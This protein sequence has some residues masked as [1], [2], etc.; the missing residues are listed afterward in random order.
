LDHYR[1]RRSLIYRNE[2]SAS[3]YI[4]QREKS[5]L[6]HLLSPRHGERILNIVSSNNNF[7]LFL[8]AQGYQ[9]TIFDLEGKSSKIQSPRAELPFSDNEFDIVT[10][11]SSLEVTADPQKVIAEACRVSRGS[12][13]L[14]VLNRHSFAGLNKR[15]RHLA[16]SDVK[17][18]HLFSIGQ[19]KRMIRNALGGNAEIRWGSVIFLPHTCY[20]FAG[21]VEENIPVYKNPFGAFL[22]LSFSVA[23]RYRTI[24]ERISPFKLRLK[25]PEIQGTVRLMNKGCAPQ[26][27]SHSEPEKHF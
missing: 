10:L 7:H 16:D 11:I 12:V 3:R 17:R 9:V 5:L 24:Q 26:L 1:N 18:G 14:G 13:F 4:D 6:M 25:S 21:I 8:K 22:G 23:F 20:S 27:P 19:L 2:I 15:I